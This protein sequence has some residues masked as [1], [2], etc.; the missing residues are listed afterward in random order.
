MFSLTSFYRQLFPV[1]CFEN[2]SWSSANAD[3]EQAF[4]QKAI[5]ISQVSIQQ[6]PGEVT[7][8]KR[9]STEPGVRKMLDWL[10]SGALIAS[11]E[12]HPKRDTGCHI[13]CT[14]EAFIDCSSH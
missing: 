8:L 12:V 5:G 9:E 1:D 4:A 6:S 14:R 11:C 13:R 10:V 7:R 3:A 2:I